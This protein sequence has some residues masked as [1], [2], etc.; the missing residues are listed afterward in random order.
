MQ[1]LSNSRKPWSKVT[2]CKCRLCVAAAIQVSRTA[3]PLNL[4]CV[5]NCSTFGHS[6]LNDGK[7]QGR[8]QHG[9]KKS[10]SR[11]RETWFHKPLSRQS[12]SVTQ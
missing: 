10:Q 2:R 3:L 7:P 6:S 9:T 4:C 8:I 5:H 11:H 1:G 12:T